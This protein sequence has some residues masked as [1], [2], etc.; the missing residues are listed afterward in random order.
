[1]SSHNHT[2]YSSIV[3]PIQ[4]SIVSPKRSERHWHMN[5]ELDYV[6]EGTLQIQI[7]EH[8]YYL[9]KDQLVLINSYDV[10]SILSDDC[11]LV[12]LEIDLSKYDQKLVNET[13]LRFDCNSATNQNQE[14]FR[15]LKSKIAHF[16]HV[17]S[18]EDEYNSYLNKS[19]AYSILHNL[20][21]AFKSEPLEENF[22]KKSNISRMEE[23]LKYINQHYQENITLKDLAENFFLTVPYMSKI[24]KEYIGTTFTEY[25]ESIRLSHAF[26]ILGQKSITIDTVAEQS[27]FP[28]TRSFVTSFKRIYGQLPSQYRKSLLEKSQSWKQAPKSD[29]L[30][31]KYHHHYLDTLSQYLDTSDYN[32]GKSV[33]PIQLIEIPPVSVAQK[34]YALNHSFH[35][36]TCISKAKHILFAENQ[37][38]L[39]ELQKEIGFKYIKFHGL[40]DDDMMVYSELPDGTPQI[41]FIY[42]DM[43]VDFLLSINLRP[44]IQFSFMPKDLSIDN[45]YVQFYTKSIISLPKSME[46]WTFLIRELV[47]HLLSRYGSDEVERWPFSLWNEPDSPRDMFG[48]GSCE[49]YFH[50]YKHTYN[51]VKKCNPNISFGAP[52]VLPYTI[53]NGSWM[54]QFLSL[55]KDEGCTPSFMNFHFYPMATHVE[56]LPPDAQTTQH[57]LYLK[58]PDALKE[59]IY[60]IKS[61][62]KKYNWNIDTLYMTEWN[63]SIS[64][65]ELLNDTSFKAAYVI[66]NILDNYDQLD[67]FGYWVL[68]D[69]LEET[70]MTEELFHG[71]LGLF[72]Y[73][74]I[75]KP[76]FYAFRLLN[77]LGNRLIG[78]GDGYFI[79][80]EKECFQIIF[81]NYQHYSDLYASGEL[82]DMTFTNRY[83]PF[84]TANRKKYVIPLAD[85]TNNEYILTETI[86]NRQN[87]S[88][89]DKWIELGALPLETTDDVNYLKSVSVPLIRKRRLSVENNYLTISCELEPH[90]VRLIEIR[91]LYQ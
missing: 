66:K 90:E 58:S 75:K 91:A 6:L 43:V 35:N 56:H 72:T 50:F 55:C 39:T 16:I 22:I 47:L 1:M 9:E 34:G 40:L 61:N 14:L 86:I 12:S 21:T 8:T 65:R 68:S 78:R 24:F 11:V 25:L 18:V 45:N 10:H 76:P 36:T 79:T 88:A 27:G 69:W 33:M 31:N 17:N 49:E 57:M 15:S 71:G 84:P 30:L 53:Q 67:S 3:T 32:T 85:V 48:L 62:S 81:Y 59:C 23:I 2:L 70:M 20:V 89:F 83:T 5:I 44:F 28:N 82:F 73:N 46:K 74:G 77:K 52:S 19:L 26:Q 38:M 64:Q 80:K 42:I 13:N 87:G 7:N 37:S 60:N 29:A 54:D 4:A 41:S 63:S 51:T